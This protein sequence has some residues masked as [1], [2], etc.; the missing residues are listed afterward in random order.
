MPQKNQHLKFDDG[1][2]YHVGEEQVEGIKKYLDEQ[3]GRI[4]EEKNDE[5]PQLEGGRL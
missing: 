1:T 3:I 5:K 2:S 4:G